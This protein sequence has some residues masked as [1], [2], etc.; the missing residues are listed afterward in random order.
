M[1][2][3][4]SPIASRAGFAAVA[5][6]ALAVGASPLLASAADHLDAPAAKAD[7][8]VDITDVYAFR[9]SAST[10]TLVLNVDGLMSPG[11][12][13]DRDVP[14]ERAVRAQGRPQPGRQGRPRLSRPVLAGD[15]ER[16]RHQDPGLRRPTRTTGASADSNVWKGKVVADGP[17]HA[18]QARRAHRAREAAADR[19]SPAPATIR[20]SSTSRAS[21]SSR[22]SSWA[23]STDLG[24]LLG[25]FTG[26]G[27]LRR[28]QRPL[29][30]ASKLPNAKL[31]GTGNSVGVWGDDVRR[32]ATAAG[33][34]ST[35]WVGPRSTPCSTACSCPPP[36]P[37]TASRRTPS[38]SSARPRTPAPR[39][40]NVDHRAQRDRQRPDRQR[41][42]G[43]HGGRGRRRSRPCCCRTSSRSRSAA[44]AGFAS[45]TSL[46]DPRA[47]R[48]RSWPTTSSTPSSPCSRTS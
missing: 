10:T 23:G 6:M 16:R 1:R 21:S 33:R 9:S 30:R 41:R 43:V 25:G 17:H 45:G 29:D 40:D 11:R 32:V 34:R 3:S 5:G 31:G 13:Q 44:V 37:T 26:S 2:S 20:S 28:D 35:A 4:I 22:S 39:T 47:Q 36:R 7:H 42:D 19:S 15:D 8:R 48:P 27:H 18:V 12:Q 14:S 46:G 38:T 24:D